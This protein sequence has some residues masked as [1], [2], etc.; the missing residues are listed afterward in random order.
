MTPRVSA[1]RRT[2]ATLTDREVRRSNQILKIDAATARWARSTT[3]ETAAARSAR[4]LHRIP[5]AAATSYVLVEPVTQPLRTV[6]PT[7]RAASHQ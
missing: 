4:S 3:R 5:T 1:A 6:A 7:T 2:R